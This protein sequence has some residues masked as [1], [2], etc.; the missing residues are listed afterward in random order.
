MTKGELAAMLGPRITDSFVVAGLLTQHDADDPEAL[1]T[2]EKAGGEPVRIN[3]RI[4]ESDLLIH[5]TVDPSDASAYRNLAGRITA[6]ESAHRFVAVG[7]DDAVTSFGK[8]LEARTPV[9]QVALSLNNAEF[10]GRSSFLQSRVNEWTFADRSAFKALQTLL[11]LTPEPLRDRLLQVPPSHQSVIAVA[12]G[13]VTATNEASLAVLKK[14]YQAEEAQPRD[15]LALGAA[16]AS[17]FAVNSILNPLLAAH[18]A[19]TSAVPADGRPSLVR[20]GG[21]VI[22]HHGLTK[23][24]DPQQQPSFIDFFDRV[25]PA[26]N[27]DDFD[28]AEKVFADDAWYSHLYRTSYAHHGTLPFRLWAECERARRH[29]GGVVVVG[30]DVDAAHRLGFRRASTFADAIEMAGDI[31]STDKPSITAVPY[32]APRTQAGA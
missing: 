20:E 4:A 8:A 21:V 31:T 2:L 19:L 25:L 6:T 28:K 22:L 13:S 3:K 7:S 26:E 9:F 16:P 24:F 5:L 32:P 14:Q 27:T 23:H 10:R 11:D 1:A 17:P 29:L 15:V 12:A 30:G 18:Y